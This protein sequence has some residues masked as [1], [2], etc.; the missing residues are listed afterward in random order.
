MLTWL[1]QT[2]PFEKSSWLNNG[3]SAGSVLDTLQH[4][5]DKGLETFFSPYDIF[6]C[7]GPLAFA[8]LRARATRAVVK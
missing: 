3:L 2:F 4:V 5:K 8:L 6:S 1:L 7:L